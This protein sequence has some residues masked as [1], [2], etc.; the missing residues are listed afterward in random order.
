MPLPFGNSLSKTR[1][2][3]LDAASTT[4]DWIGIW[5]LF[6]G[7]IAVLLASFVYFA[8]GEPIAASAVLIAVASIIGVVLRENAPM[9][10]PD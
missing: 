3:G 4:V 10:D 5:A 9:V 7:T 1:S 8:D 6:L 2:G